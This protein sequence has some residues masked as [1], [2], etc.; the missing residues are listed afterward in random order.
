MFSRVVGVLV[1]IVTIFALGLGVGL[2]LPRVL[3]TGARNA[4]LN[5]ATILKQ[6]QALSQ[7]VTVK[8]VY[9][10]M[11]DVPAPPSLLGQDR[12]LLLAHG[13]V[14][15]GIDFENVASDDIQVSGKKI[16][17]KLPPAIITEAYLDESQ[18]RV[19]DRNT[20]LLRRAEKDLE[21]AARQHARA[22]ITHAARAQGI[23]REAEQTARLQLTNLLQQLGFTDIDLRTKKP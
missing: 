23:E 4:P 13:I 12:V 3:Q 19:V 10:K 1:A 7:F 8:Y 20:G 21:Q 6:V 17:L 2:Y 16:S 22:E 15:A 11:V 5:S 9:E 14:K 18:T